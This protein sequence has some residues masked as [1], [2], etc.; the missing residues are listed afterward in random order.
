MSDQ[1]R[2]ASAFHSHAFLGEGHE[3]S[4]RRTWAVIWLCA[5]MML[6]EIVGGWLFGSIAL[7]ADGLHMSTHP[8]AL[9]GGAFGF[10]HDGSHLR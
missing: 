1:S 10:A 3:K 2:A 6:A 4:E 8:G 9:L 7:I 5:A